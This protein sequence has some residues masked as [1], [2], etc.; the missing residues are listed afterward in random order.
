MEVTRNLLWVGDPVIIRPLATNIER[1]LT[2]VVEIEKY[3]NSAL[4]RIEHID[5]SIILV[6]DTISLGDTRH[7]EN[8]D[9]KD[10]TAPGCYFISE[11]RK[12][13]K[14]TP[15]ILTHIGS[16]PGYSIN[17]ALK[18]YR[19]SGITDNFN[20]NNQNAYIELPDFLRDFLYNFIYIY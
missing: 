20:I 2:T 5:F 17:E 11:A 8:I 6:Q 19:K 3:A 15:I 4:E 9:P 7:T 18:R 16:F 13:L 12:K 10:W 14:S 1:E